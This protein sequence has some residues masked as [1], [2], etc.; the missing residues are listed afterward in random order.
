VVILS[1]GVEGEVSGVVPGVVGEGGHVNS[2]RVGAESKSS[3]TVLRGKSQIRKGA[4]APRSSAGAMK[5]LFLFHVK[6]LL[7]LLEWAVKQCEI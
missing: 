3:F 6:H 5:Q 1:T 2:S 4:G 7:F